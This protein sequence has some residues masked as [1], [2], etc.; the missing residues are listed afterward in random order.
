MSSFV[1]SKDPP[2]PPA[3]KLRIVSWQIG[4]WVPVVRASVR[5]S[6][7]IEVRNGVG[8]D[9]VA[10]GTALYERAAPV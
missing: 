7:A 4:S 1:L 8:E 9:S 5:R 6:V 2:L 10:A 3:A